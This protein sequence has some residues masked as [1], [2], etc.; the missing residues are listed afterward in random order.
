MPAAPALGR[1]R[2]L[3]WAP[4]VL[5]RDGYTVLYY[6]ARFETAGLQCLGCAVSASPAGTFR[7][8]SV[9]PFLCQHDLGGSIDP[10]PFVDETGRPYLLWKND[11]NSCGLPTGC[12]LQIAAPDL[13]GA[14]SVPRTAALRSALGTPAHR[15]AGPGQARYGRYSFYSPTG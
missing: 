3:T 9:V 12:R 2:C 14:G 6:T 13:P 8:D 7:D 4:S 10:S 5:P 15:G 11:G 1:C